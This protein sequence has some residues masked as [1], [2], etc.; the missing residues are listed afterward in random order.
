MSHLVSG[1]P[2]CHCCC[3]M[4][5]SPKAWYLPCNYNSRNLTSG[6]GFSWGGQTASTRF[7][8]VTAAGGVTSSCMDTQNT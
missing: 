7:S 2:P 1:K 6:R 4:L 5:Q 3:T 8:P